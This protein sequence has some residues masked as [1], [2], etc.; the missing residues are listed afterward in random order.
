MSSY[1]SY[2]KVFALGHA[3]IKNI[4]MDNVIVQEKID[5]SQFSFG[6]F[7]G[8]IKC[9]SK[10]KQ[11]QLDNPEKMFK[12]AIQTVI[13]L[14]DKLKNG[15]TYRGEYLKK[16]QHNTLKYNR[17][18][19]N[20]IIIFDINIEQEDYLNY[21]EV[22]KEC[23]RLG[24]ECV[25][26]FYEGEIKNT[27]KVLSFLENESVLGGCKIEGMVFKNYNQVGVDGKVL[28][29]KYVSEKFKEIHNKVWK[30]KNPTKKDI[31]QLIIA[32]LKTEARWEKSI[33]HLKEKSL[34]LNETKDIGNLIKEI[35]EDIKNECNDYIKEKLYNYAINQILRG[36][37][38]GFPEWYKG[39]L[40]ENQFKNK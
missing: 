21:E 29:G 11:I 35:Q 36:C 33:Q 31:I 19:K 34:L 27:D 24:L 6:V 38:S 32:S 3:M 1:H 40:L 5:G 18:P 20:H 8:E 7:D 23:D 39:K 9:R 25:P 14:K 37:V 28:M 16:P 22:E 2:P 15:W 26:K 30:E 12:E 10:G 4:F 17:I 13:M